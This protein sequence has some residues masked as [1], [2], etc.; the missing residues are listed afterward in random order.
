MY[1]AEL[2][3]DFAI[4][5]DNLVD[6]LKLRGPIFPPSIGHVFRRGAN[7]ENW[8]QRNRTKSPPGG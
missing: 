6:S 4:M 8:G 5:T 3:N 2:A 7:V 1:F